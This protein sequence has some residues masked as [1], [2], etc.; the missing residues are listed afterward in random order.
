MS[1]VYLALHAAFLFASIPDQALPDDFIVAGDGSGDYKTIQAAIEAAPVNATRPFVILIKKGTYQEKIFIDKPFITLVGEDRDSTRIIYAELRSNWRKDH[2]DDDWG[3]AVVNIGDK[4]NN[5]T[6]ANLTIYNNYGLLSGEHDHQFA[7]RSFGATRII[8]INCTIKADG[9]DTLSLWNKISGMYFHADCYFEGWVDYVCPR[10]WCYITNCRFFGHN[11]PSASI[12]HD[13]DSDADQKLVIRNSYFDGRPNFPLGRNHRDAQFYLLDCIF[14]ENMADRPIYQA[15]DSTAYQWGK[16][17]YYYNNHRPAGDYSW[18]ADNLQQ[19]KGSPLPEQITPTWTFQ[20]KWD[21]EKNIPAVLPYAYRL[22]PVQGQV[23]TVGLESQLKW[24]PARG[25]KSYKVY[26]GTSN[27]PD[28]IASVSEPGYAP[29]KLRPQTTYFWRIDVVTAAGIN[30]GT[31][32]SFQT[33]TGQGG[34]G[35]N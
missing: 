34:R 5:L 29:G 3:S 25:A 8:I 1:I 10:G 6:L 24:L 14:S 18:Y 13:G 33:E 4:A 26:F 9:G 17:Y 32:W 11:T 19:A 35:D 12:W 2:P 22:E 27:P 28:F 23:K 30:A 21:P 7:V 20:Y 31:V 15:K 16:R